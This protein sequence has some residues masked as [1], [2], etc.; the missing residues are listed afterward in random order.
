VQKDDQQSIFAP[1]GSV[2]NFDP[3]EMQILQAA[4]DAITVDL[5]LSRLQIDIE[6]LQNKLFELSLDGKIAQ[7]A[8]G[9]WK[10]V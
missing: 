4:A 9:F 10:R 2:E 3:I 7:D 8:M 1:A 6:T 5:M